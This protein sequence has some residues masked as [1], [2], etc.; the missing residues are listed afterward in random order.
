[1]ATTILELEDALALVLARLGEV[2]VRYGHAPERAKLTKAIERFLTAQ[3]ANMLDPSPRAR[4]K[5]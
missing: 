3:R 5:A 1:M 4:Q 2:K